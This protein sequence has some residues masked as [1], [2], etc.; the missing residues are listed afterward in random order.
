[1]SN[2][3]NTQANILNLQL[4]SNEVIHFYTDINEHLLNN[5]VLIAKYSN[6]LVVSQKLTAYAS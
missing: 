2:I 1:M 5:V 3:K 4:T 6:D